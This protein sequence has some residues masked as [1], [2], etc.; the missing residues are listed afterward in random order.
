MGFLFL[1]LQKLQLGR[2]LTQWI[3]VLY[4]HQVATIQYV[5]SQSNPIKIQRGFRQGCPLLPLLFYLV[6]EKLGLA[7]RQCQ[8]I[9][10]VTAIFNMDGAV[11]FLQDLLLRTFSALKQV[12]MTFTRASG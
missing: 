1:N 10:G 2:F 4:T 5:G 7:V 11:F 3:Q 6:I 9:R 8:D 12:I